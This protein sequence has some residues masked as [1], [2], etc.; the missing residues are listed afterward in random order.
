MTLLSI[1]AI[2]IG[3]GAFGLFV[4]LRLCRSD[5][6]TPVARGRVGANDDTPSASRQRA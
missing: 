2:A 1:F 4:A 6:S 3:F 5:K